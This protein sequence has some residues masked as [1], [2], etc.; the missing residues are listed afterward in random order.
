MKVEVP[1]THPP[2]YEVDETVTLVPPN[3]LVD[4]CNRWEQY[5]V[6]GSGKT[7]MD[8]I[9]FLLS[10]G[11]AVDQIHWIAPNDAWLFNRAHIQVGAVAEVILAHAMSVRDAANA[12]DIFIEMEKTGGIVRIDE[13]ISPAKWRCA[14]VSP[15][16][17]E[18]LR[19]VNHIIR[20]GRV[21]RITNSEIQ[22]QQGHVA[23]AKR[24]LFI[25]CSANGLA[26]REQT[27]IFAAGKITLQSILFCQQVFS[28]AAIARLSMTNLS[29]EK[30]NQL[31]PVP[32][33]EFKEDWPSTLATSLENL[34]LL[35]RFFPMWMFRSRL[36]FMSHEPMV[37]YFSNAVKAIFLSPA[38]RKAASRID[39]LQH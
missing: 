12:E 21:N 13:S 19:R 27:P 37:K 34:L 28:A 31:I 7:G 3:D 2:E 25:D 18:Q 5:Y 36:N 14:T 16:E 33:P 11:I 10:N 20:K 35:H 4:E 29:D 15:D 32:H 30:R 26:K 1:A 9:L 23:F 39:S 24:S 8:A 38:V 6:I 22:L 17:L